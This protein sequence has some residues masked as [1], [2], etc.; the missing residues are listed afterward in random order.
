MK[1][2]TST[3]PSSDSSEEDAGVEDAGDEDSDDVGDTDAFEPLLFL[4]G[5]ELGIDTISGVEIGVVSV[6]DS[7]RWF[8]GWAGLYCWYCWVRS[9]KIIRI[10]TISYTCICWI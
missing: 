1:R 5:V 6:K 3:S 10:C 7:S 8:E 2:L 4:L 9:W